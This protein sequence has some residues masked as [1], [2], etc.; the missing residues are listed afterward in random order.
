MSGANKTKFLGLS[1]RF[2][3]PRKTKFNNLTKP[4]DSIPVN[5]I[6]SIRCCFKSNFQ[7]FPFSEEF[8]EF[9]KDQSFPPLCAK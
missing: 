2:S 4:D 8:K 3:V 9:P 6:N 1:P 5:S 7:L